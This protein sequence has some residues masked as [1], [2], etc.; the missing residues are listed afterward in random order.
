[1]LEFV[2]LVD[3]RKGRVGGLFAA[4]ANPALVVA[5]VNIY[6]KHSGYHFLELQDSKQAIEE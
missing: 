4:R 1:M 2:C 3:Q 5:A 6:M